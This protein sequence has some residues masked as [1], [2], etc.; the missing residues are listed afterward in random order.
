MSEIGVG[1]RRANNGAT[2]QPHWHL[3]LPSAARTRMLFAGAALVASGL[4]GLVLWMTWG[5]YRLAW[6]R[7]TQASGNLTAT[8]ANDIE[9][10]VESYDLSLQAVIIGLRFRDT[11]SLSPEMRDGLLF[12][13]AATA[14]QFGAIRVTDASGHVVLNSRSKLYG[15]PAD[16]ETLIGQDCFRALRD[17]TA[18]GLFVGAPFRDAASGDWVIALAR[19]Y[20]GPD[21]DFAGIVAG[22]LRLDYLRRLFGSVTLDPNAS[23]TLFRSDRTILMRMPFDEQGIGRRLTGAPVFR[24]L[25]ASTSGLFEDV[26][27]FDGQRRLFTYRKLGDLPLILALGQSSVAIMSEWHLKA[28]IIGI[29]VFGLLAI[30]GLLA[31][32]LHAELRHRDQTESQLA[33]KNAALA[34]ILHEMP[35]GIQVFDRAG[36]LIAWNE[37]VFTLTDLDAEQRQ[38]IRTTS[39]PDA[40]PRHVPASQCSD[41]VRGRAGGG[42]RCGACRRRTAAGSA[43]TATLVTRWRASANW[44]MPTSGCAR[45]RRMRKGQ[46]ERNPN[47]SPT[48]RM[49]CARR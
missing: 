8:L 27:A 25:E 35:D 6:E 34:A 44:P 24:H 20:D 41:G 45:R 3:R 30:I 40:R 33:Q 29:V 47:F 5:A 1:Q 15:T 42:S 16:D 31:G 21:G 37:Q 23:I 18:S 2:S 32:V 10:N 9:R 19:R 12:D 11:M 48:C 43:P 36:Q 38:A 39:L 28:A 46:A 14:P 13:Q 17:R 7:A 26:S 22:S 49:S 4:I